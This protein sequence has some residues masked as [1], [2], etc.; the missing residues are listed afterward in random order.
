MSSVYK[1]ITMVVLGML[2]LSAALMPN[3]APTAQSAP[4]AVITAVTSEPVTSTPTDTPPP[5]TDT[6]LPTNTSTAVPP[7]STP[8]APTSTPT[9]EP[10]QEEPREPRN[11]PTPSAIP[12]LA[13]TASPEAGGSE[14]ADPAI[15]KSSSR[16]EV[17]VGD[18]VQFT[19]TVTNRGNAAANDV[20]VTDTLPDFLSLQGATASRGEVSTSGATVTVTIGELAPGETV[21][22]EITAQVVTAPAAPNNTNIGTVTTSSGTDDPSNN[23]SSVALNALAPT[24]VPPATLPNTSATPTTNIALAL[25]GIFLIAAGLLSRRRV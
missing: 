6:P 13:L 16:A 7:D 15:T 25:L 18:Q 14:F 11:T 8:V 21:T 3:I 10:P 19:L 4:A 17:A 5:P 9:A 24:P 1:R 12:S 22:I 23:T 20:V 2:L